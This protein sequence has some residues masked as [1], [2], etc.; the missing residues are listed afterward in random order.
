[1]T[2]DEPIRRAGGSTRTLTGRIKIHPVGYGFVVPDDKSEDVHVSAR[3]RGAAMDADTVEIEAWPAV[4]GI[5]GR[6]LRVISRGRAKITGQLDRAGKQM[7]LQPDD[8]RITGPVSLR[9]HV[10][11]TLAGQAVVAEITRYPEVAGRPDRGRGP[12]GARRSRRPAHRGREGAGLR[13]RHR[14]VPRRG[15]AHRRRPAARG[16]RRGSRRPRRPARGA[17]PDH[18]PRD[19][20][21]LRRRGRDR[22]A[23]PRRHAPVGRGRRRLALRA[24]GLAGRRRG[25]QARLQHLPAQPR[26]PDAAR[27]AVGAHLLAGARRRSAGDGHADRS[28]QAR[29]GDRARLLRG[30]DP[31]ARAARLSRAWRRRWPATRAA[32]ARST[33]RTCRRCARWIRWRGRCARIGI[34]RGSL[35]FDLPEAVRRARPRRSAPGAR[36]P[37][38]AAR[39]R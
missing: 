20:A 13:R 18:R 34:S 25:A 31:L 37:Q 27:A 36:H 32:S 26:D 11:A 1:M 39:S 5:E 24:R 6:V 33:S 23:A 8:P 29:A 9:G 28:R 4:R 16:A 35:D 17:V 10:A 38:V 2:L 19:R 21:R 22:A 30:G 14:G 3:S 15:R 7:V 12:E